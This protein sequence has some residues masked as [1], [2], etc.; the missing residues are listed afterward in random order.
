MA[1]SFRQ[2]VILMAWRARGKLP[3]RAGADRFV[4][5]PR[6][7]EIFQHAP[8]RGD[9]AEVLLPGPVREVSRH[10]AANSAQSG[11]MHVV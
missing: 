11:P 8:G 4:D 3:G 10:P 2:R 7:A 9:R 1:T 5:D 6:H